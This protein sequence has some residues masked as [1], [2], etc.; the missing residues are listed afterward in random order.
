M[1]FIFSFPWQLMLYSTRYIYF[2]LT[3]YY[4]CNKCKQLSNEETVSYERIDDKS[5]P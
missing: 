1:R 5:C 2:C 3:I 4:R